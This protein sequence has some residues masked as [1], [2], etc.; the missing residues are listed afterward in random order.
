MRERISIHPARFSLDR[1]MKNHN[2]FNLI[3]LMIVVAI[4]GILAAIAVPI[5]THYVYRSKQV[6]AKTLLMT[7]KTEQEQFRAENQ[8]YTTTLLD[9]GLDSNTAPDLPQSY[10]LSLSA[11]WYTFLTIP[12]A[13]STGFRA[14]ARGRVA[15]GRPEDIWFIRQNMMYATHT[16]AEM[17]Y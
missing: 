9:S 10:Q 13:D 3:E 14:E 1:T 7:I 17:V 16:G 8:S 11:K 6:E 2:G 15:D 4:I 5:Y 12:S